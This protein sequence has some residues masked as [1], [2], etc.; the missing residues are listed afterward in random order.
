LTQNTT[1]EQ[2]TGTE[3]FTFEMEGDKAVSVGY[4]INSKDLILK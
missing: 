1:F 4:N 2:G 3:T